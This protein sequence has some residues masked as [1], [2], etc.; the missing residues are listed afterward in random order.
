M[1]TRSLESGYATPEYD[2][3]RKYR[4]ATLDDI[5]RCRGEFPFFTVQGK[6]CRCRR[7]GMV[8]RWK[9]DRERFEA[10]VKYGMY[11]CWRADNAMQAAWSPGSL[12]VAE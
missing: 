4:L 12:L 10:P 1:E 7:N 3:A 6:V 9:R 2:G 5:E 11:E 8:K